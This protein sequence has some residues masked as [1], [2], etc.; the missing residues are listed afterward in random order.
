MFVA[1]K[2]KRPQRERQRARYCCREILK[3]REDGKDD[4]SSSST[5]HNEGNELTLLLHCIGLSE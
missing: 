1:H 4:D 2:H 3:A 5:K